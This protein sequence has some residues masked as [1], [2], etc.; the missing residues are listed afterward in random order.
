MDINI[1]LK[2]KKMTAYRL[3]K[4]SGLPYTTVNDICKG[5]T[6]IEKCS[7][8]TVYKISKAT[9]VPMEELI[10]HY[11]VERPDFENFKSV[12]CHRVKEMGDYHFIVET[13]KSREI[14]KYYERKWYPE[15]LYL[16]AMLDYISRVNDVPLC[17]EYDDMRKCKLEKTVY[18]SSLY[19]YFVVTKDKSIMEKAKETAIPEFVRFNIVENEVRNV[20]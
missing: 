10:S 14:H 7:A 6:K 5:K 9:G 1:I 17:N 2:S 15:C 20:V 11:I 8:E 3:A 4:Q 16:L 18:P 13:L 12:I 19:A